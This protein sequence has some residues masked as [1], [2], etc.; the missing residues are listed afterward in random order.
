MRRWTLWTNARFNIEN[1]DAGAK[2][3]VERS[4]SGS[5]IRWPDAPP[6]VCARVLPLEWRVRRIVRMAGRRPI[7]LFDFQ[8]RMRASRALLVLFI[9]R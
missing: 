2:T 7:Q 4:E 9:I 3:F 1:V 5:D 8:K 6:R